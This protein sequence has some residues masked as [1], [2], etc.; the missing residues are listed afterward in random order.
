MYGHCQLFE[1]LENRADTF[2]FQL[3]VLCIHICVSSSCSFL[4]GK[5]PF[6][7]RQMLLRCVR[8][9]LVFAPASAPG[10]DEQQLRKGAEGCPS[11]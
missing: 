9:V 5:A 3:A 2:V 6:W 11:A 7:W 1:L 8:A 4:V 10:C